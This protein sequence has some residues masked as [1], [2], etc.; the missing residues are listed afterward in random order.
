VLRHS[1]GLPRD[2]EAE[3]KIPNHNAAKHG[4]YCSA[5][6]RCCLSLRRSVALAGVI[7]VGVIALSTGTVLASVQPVPWTTI[8]LTGL[9]QEVEGIA[10]QRA[11]TC[12]AVG[13]VPSGIA[14]GGVL[15][16]TSDAGHTWASV[17]FSG[18]NGTV[19]NG[20]ACSVKASCVAVGQISAGGGGVIE[21]SSDAGKTWARHT[22]SAAAMLYGAACASARMCEVVGTSSRRTGV[23]ESTSDGGRTW[24]LQRALVGISDIDAI[25]CPT[26]RVCVAV[27]DEVSAERET[28]V[29]VVSGDAGRTWKK[30]VVPKALFLDGVACPSV[31][32]C[33]VVGFGSSPIQPTTPGI[34]VTSTDGGRTWARAVVPRGVYGLRGVSCTS[35]GACVAVG[36]SGSPPSYEGFLL[37]T[38]RPVARW[39]QLTGPGL[40][41]ALVNSVSCA[42]PSRC[43]A[44][45]TGSGGG[46]LIF[47]GPT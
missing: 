33:T 39:K 35:T 18:A 6:R 20:I 12:I 36:E 15:L 7:A 13:F 17:S 14:P 1:R 45:G 23:V 21:V 37:G 19:L 28:G 9:V 8:P 2:K 3:G 41:G 43:V 11:S 22:T 46:G 5:S 10:C 44:G 24:H 31:N 26:T 47:V 40:S 29:I 27:G 38:Q 34:V 42:L 4:H 30:T 25:S 16:R 32:R